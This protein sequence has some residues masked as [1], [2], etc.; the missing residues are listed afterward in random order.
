MASAAAATSVISSTRSINAPACQ[1]FFSWLS[2]TSPSLAEMFGTVWSLSCGRTLPWMSRAFSP[3]FVEYQSIDITSRSAR[4]ATIASRSPRLR[5]GR[6][7]PAGGGAR[8]EALVAEAAPG[9][10]EHAERGHD[11]QVEPDVTRVGTRRER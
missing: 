10:H 2:A 9:A 3:T 11:A 5:R 7:L 8:R 1:A 6:A 4:A